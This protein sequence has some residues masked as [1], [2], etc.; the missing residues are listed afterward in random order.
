M[1]QRCANKNRIVLK[2]FT[3]SSTADVGGREKGASVEL[4]KS[5]EQIGV[6]PTMYMIKDTN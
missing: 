4:L 6:H 2:F 3:R 5:L 1:D